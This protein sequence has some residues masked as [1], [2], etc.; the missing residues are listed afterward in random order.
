[1]ITKGGESD[2]KKALDNLQYIIFLLL[3]LD[4]NN[5]DKVINIK[6]QNT[7]DS[8]IITPG[9]PIDNILNL[10]LNNNNKDAETIKTHIK[11][12]HAKRLIKEID[13]DNN[14]KLRKPQGLE[15]MTFSDLI[16]NQL[17]K[18]DQL[19]NHYFEKEKGENILNT[20]ISIFNNVKSELK[21]TNLYNELKFNQIS[22]NNQKINNLKDIMDSANNNEDVNLIFKLDTTLYNLLLLKV[23]LSA[24]YRGYLF[25]SIPDTFYFN[26]IENLLG[27]LYNCN[28]DQIL[29]ISSKIDNNSKNNYSDNI[30]KLNNPPASQPDISKL[31]SQ[32]SSAIVMPQTQKNNPSNQTQNNPSNQT[33]N[34]PSNQTLIQNQANNNDKDII[35]QLEDSIELKGYTIPA[36]DGNS[37]ATNSKGN[38]LWNTAIISHLDLPYNTIDTVDVYL[39]NMF[40]QISDETTG[41]M[42]KRSVQADK[43]I[44]N[45][46]SKF[47]FKSENNIKPLPQKT[48]GGKKTKGKKIYKNKTRRKYKK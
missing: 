46:K 18:T 41:H 1:M 27:E 37:Y 16:K 30:L 10:L 39:Y 4:N 31:F 2:K 28:S 45:V 32:V 38:I 23:E 26:E 34:N 24:Q 44:K 5:H 12:K 42:Q 20:I 3:Y 14:R 29:S 11:F 36:K 35:K 17:N 22:K 21:N 15:K 47:T 9:R 33:Q 7:D 6:S 25:N 13:E 8:Y 43:G 40:K 19:N 48:T